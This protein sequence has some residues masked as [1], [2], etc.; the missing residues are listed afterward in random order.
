MGLREYH[1]NDH[2]QILFPDEVFNVVN[3]TTTHKGF[4]VIRYFLIV[5]HAREQ[6]PKE[7][8]LVF[9]RTCDT[10]ENVIVVFRKIR[11]FLPRT[12]PWASTM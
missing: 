4:T 11:R 2:I 9:R 8:R 3:S 10:L 5:R 7:P 12:L 1:M 6:R